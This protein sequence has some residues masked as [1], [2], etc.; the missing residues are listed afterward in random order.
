MPLPI[1][2]LRPQLTLASRLLALAISFSVGLMRP[3][4]LTSAPR[5]RCLPLV[6]LWV[7]LAGAPVITLR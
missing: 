4:R 6:M 5:L 2:K 7:G 3:A 1:W